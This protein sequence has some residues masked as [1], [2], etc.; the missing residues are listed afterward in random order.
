MDCVVERLRRGN[1]DRA[2][3]NGDLVL[4]V[5]VACDAVLVGTAGNA[6]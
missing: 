3:G 6:E 5:E 4:D 1:G 2:R